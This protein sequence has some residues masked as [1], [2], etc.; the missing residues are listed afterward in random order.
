GAVGG[1]VEG[2]WVRGGWVKETTVIRQLESKAIR[3][4]DSLRVRIRTSYLTRNARIRGHARGAMV[5]RQIVCPP[6]KKVPKKVPKGVKIGAAKR[7]VN[8]PLSSGE[9]IQFAAMGADTGVGTGRQLRSN[10]TQAVCRCGDCLPEAREV[11]QRPL[12]ARP[13]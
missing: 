11:M 12:S 5:R 3:P 1:W 4:S 13:G 2:G 9:I 6:R 7:T 10:A 8:R